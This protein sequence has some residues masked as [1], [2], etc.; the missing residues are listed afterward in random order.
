MIVLRG[1]EEISRIRKAGR[2]VA[3][4]L[5]A[6]R[7]RV[8]PGIETG[9]L[10]A[11]ARSEILRRDGFPAFKDYKGFPGNICVSVNEV[12]VHGIPSSRKLKEGDIVSL[13]V[14]VK[15]RD[16]FADAAA[17][18]PVG[19]IS[20]KARRL[21]EV[22][23][24]AL[25]IAVD[26]AVSGGRL[27]DVSAGIQEFVESEGF[28]VVRVFVGHGIGTKLHEEPEIPNF[29]KPG[30]GPRLEPGMVLAIEP[31]VNEGTCEAEILEDGWTAVTAD[32]R[33]SAH[34]EHT[35]TV[36]PEG[37]AEILTGI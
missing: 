31:M 13:D 33:L 4:T 12:I 11:L 17:T 37:P 16:Y 9:E 27:S 22:T 21:I 20:G 24:K 36:R 3:A 10:D 7:K 34:F 5:E 1:D 14:G 23:E 35:V 30:L 6:L 28:S 25:S 15:F 32:G 19:K 18:Y 26:R 29:G 2:I 8:A